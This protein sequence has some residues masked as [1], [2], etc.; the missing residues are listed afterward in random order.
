MAMGV[1][2]FIGENGA[3]EPRFFSSKGRGGF[4]KEKNL[5]KIAKFLKKTKKMKDF[6]C[7]ILDRKLEMCYNREVKKGFSCDF[8]VPDDLLL[9]FKE[10]NGRRIQAK[11]WLYLKKRIHY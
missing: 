2:E 6:F 5:K 10:K 1:V 8:S 3:K 11:R 4:E 7:K 9:S